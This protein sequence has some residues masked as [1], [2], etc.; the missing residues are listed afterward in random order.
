MSIKDDL[1]A[2]R[3]DDSNPIPDPGLPEHQPRP[4]DIDS[5]AE[6]RAERQVATL[7]VLSMICTVLFFVSYFVFEVGDDWDAIGTL[8]AST[9]ALGA[10]LGGAMLFL[11]FGVVQWARK[12]MS[13]HELVEK[14]H[15]ASS[16]AEDRREAL[17]ALA[18]GTEDSGI[19]RRPLIRNTLLG[20][21]GLASV[22]PVVLLRDLG[23]T[24]GDALKTTPWTRGMRVVR[25]VAGTPIKPEDLDLGTL[26]NGQPAALFE[27]GDDGEPLFEGV[28]LQVAKSKASVILVRMEPR[29]IQPVDGREDW[30]IDGIMCFSKIC[31]HVGCPIALYNQK[32]KE[33]LCP[34]HQSTFN[35]A[36]GAKVTFGPAN[37]PLPQLPLAVDDEGY[38]IAASGFLEPVGPSFWERDTQQFEKEVGK[39]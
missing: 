36:D 18:A 25:D 12:L 13:D 15:P 39:P 11:G 9:V 32:T 3:V 4:T 29:D 33:V 1:P 31:T 5:H 19:T 30:T 21:L 6:R 27:V 2:V 35:L 20:A 26:V 38:L 14:R 10:T 34:C 7:F 22:S 23:P 37:R 8:G 24:P 17:A 16:S 28:D